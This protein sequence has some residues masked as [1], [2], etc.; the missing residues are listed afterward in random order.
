[1]IFKQWRQVLD[2][3]KTQ[4]RRLVKEGDYG[5]VCGDNGK[6]PPLLQLSHSEVISGGRLRWQRGR[7]YAVQPGRG[8]KA[9]GRI[10]ITGIRRERLQSISFRDRR[11]EGIERAPQIGKD[12]ETIRETVNMMERHAFACLWDSIHKKRGVCWADNPEVWVLEFEA[13]AQERTE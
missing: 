12:T 13:V 2:S 9:V 5:W 3:T 10:R 8:K 6:K 7:T 1:M 4:T 11:A